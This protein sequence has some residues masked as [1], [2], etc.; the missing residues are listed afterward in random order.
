MKFLLSLKHRLLTS[1][2]LLV[3]SKF[4]AYK[5]QAALYR[6]KCFYQF[7]TNSF[8]FFFPKM[9]ND[10]YNIKPFYLHLTCPC[11]P[12]SPLRHLKSKKHF[13][14][15]LIFFWIL[16]YFSGLLSFLCGLMFFCPSLNIHIPQVLFVGTLFFFLFILIRLLKPHSWFQLPLT[17]YIYSSKFCLELK[18]HKSR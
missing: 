6:S 1:H 11:W 15:N 17:C 7:G 12:F 5:N 3:M 14:S 2:F 13:L 4:W 18:T 8:L 16:S 9:N 10:L